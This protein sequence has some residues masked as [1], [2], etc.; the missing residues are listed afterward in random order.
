MQI[1]AFLLY[2]FGLLVDVGLLYVSSFLV[3]QFFR[4]SPSIVDVYISFGNSS[5]FCAF[6]VL[7]LGT[8]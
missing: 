6:A 7:H 5:Q 2:C 3:L 4:V 1:D 8:K